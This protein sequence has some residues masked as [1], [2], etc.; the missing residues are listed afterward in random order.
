MHEFK[1]PRL[2][3]WRICCCSHSRLTIPRLILLLLIVVIVLQ[4]VHMFLLSRMQNHAKSESKTADNSE[5]GEMIKRIYES[6]ELDATGSYHVIANVAMCEKCIPTGPPMYERY[7]IT[8]VT[9]T[10]LNN[11]HHIVNMASQWQGPIGV[12]VFAFDDG[13]VNVLVAIATL[14]K[15]HP[16]VLKTVTFHLAYPLHRFPQNLNNAYDTALVPCDELPKVF[17]SKIPNYSF[18]DIQ[19]PHN[20]L[21]NV[22][23]KNTKTEFVFMIDIDMLPSLGLRKDFSKFIEVA[24]K[25]LPNLTAF[26]IPSFEAKANVS[27]PADKKALLKQWDAGEIRPFYYEVCWKC[28]RHTDYDTW[29]EIDASQ[30][31]IAYNVPWKDPWEPFFITRRFMPVFDERFKQYGFNRISHVCELHVAGYTLSVLSNAFLIHQGFKFPDKFHSTKTKELNMNR[32]LFRKFKEELKMKYPYS[33]KRC[34]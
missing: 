33:Q 26:V 29:K 22:A 13:I 25:F 32:M 14:R 5:I 18:D 7:E 31:K 6:H 2:A 10:S 8:I 24:D 21:R 3:Y 19:Y 15:C 30:L 4:G 20:M 9:Q 11:L 12:T 23:I 17:E 1:M 16:V 27:F 28:Q 34:Y